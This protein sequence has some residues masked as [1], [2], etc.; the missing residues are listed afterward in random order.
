MNAGPSVLWVITL[1]TTCSGKESN[2]S[3]SESPL[4]PRSL[5]YT[6]HKT[7]GSIWEVC[8]KFCPAGDAVES[9]TFLMRSNCS[10]EK[11]VDDQWC[12]RQVTGKNL[13]YHSKTF[14]FETWVEMDMGCMSLSSSLQSE[15][16]VDFMQQ[17]MWAGIF[18]DTGWSH[19]N[20]CNSKKS[21]YSPEI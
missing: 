12:F 21:L 10:I 2:L 15:N 16:C 5:A 17:E 20:R 3:L 19:F 14:C 13:W 9:V 7:R 11:V 4:P 1:P 6:F 18:G 8:G